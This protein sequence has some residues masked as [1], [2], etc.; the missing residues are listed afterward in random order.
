MP[1]LLALPLLLALA[2]CDTGSAAADLDLCSFRGFDASIQADVGGGAFHELTRTEADGLASLPFRFDLSAGE[3]SS[4]IVTLSV[5]LDGALRSGTYEVPAG[6]AEANLWA[7]TDRGALAIQEVATQATLTV[8]E[9]RRSGSYADVVGSVEIAF[10]SGTLTGTFRAVDRARPMPVSGCTATG[11][12][13][14]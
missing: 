12:V 6:G 10:P 14:Y 5:P 4:R 1:R 8:T 11:C 9:V 3:S 2:A 13:V 7:S